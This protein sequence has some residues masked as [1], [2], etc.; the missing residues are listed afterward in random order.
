MSIQLARKLIAECNDLLKM[1]ERLRRVVDGQVVQY[2]TCA[3]FRLRIRLYEDY[4]KLK[5]L[6]GET[7]EIDLEGLDVMG[8][9]TS[10][11]EEYGDGFE[12][13]SIE[14]RAIY[15]S[16]M[17]EA[18]RRRRLREDSSSEEDISSEEEDPPLLGEGEIWVQDGYYTNSVGERHPRYVVRRQ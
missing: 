4:I 12:W 5:E 7:E 3:D 9:E 2:S 13:V 8:E 11:E 16:E 1:Y 17:E 15:R 14:R 10:S 18:E 6:V